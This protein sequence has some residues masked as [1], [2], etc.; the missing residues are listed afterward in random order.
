MEKSHAYEI[1]YAHLQGRHAEAGEDAYGRRVTKMQENFPIS[2]QGLI[3]G[4]FR[5]LIN[6]LSEHS[7]ANARR[8]SL[9]NASQI[10]LL[11][12]SLAQPK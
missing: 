10:D 3:L 5:L 6:S 8:R 2:K 12:S 4:E 7:V 1:M 11:R 9:S